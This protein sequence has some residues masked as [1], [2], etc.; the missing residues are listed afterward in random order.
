MCG[1]PHH[2]RVPLTARLQ[3]RPPRF[4]ERF[5]DSAGHYGF[6]PRASR[7]FQ[8]RTKERMRGPLAPDRLF[9]HRHDTSQ[10]EQL[11]EM[12]QRVDMLL[13]SQSRKLPEVAETDDRSRRS[14]ADGL[15]HAEAL[16]PS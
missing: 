14:P 6:T 16:P 12:K 4:N 15:P 2:L 11:E 7:P 10:G 1:C 13:P 9:I 8:P 5:V 3:R